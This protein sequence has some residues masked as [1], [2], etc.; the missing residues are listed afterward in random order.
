[1]LKSQRH[2]YT[3]VHGC[4]PPEVMVLADVAVVV[5]VC[6]LSP[7]SRLNEVEVGEV[8]LACNRAQAVSRDD[9]VGGSC[10]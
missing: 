5:D 8:L 9:D 1:M 4:S 6:V 2:V 10:D 3:M 7:A